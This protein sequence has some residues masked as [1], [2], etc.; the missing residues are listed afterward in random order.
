MDTASVGQQGGAAQGP[1]GCALGELLSLRAG[2]QTNTGDIVVGGNRPAQGK[3]AETF[4]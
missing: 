3:A 1:S 2:E 4:W